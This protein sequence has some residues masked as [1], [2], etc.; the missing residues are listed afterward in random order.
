MGERA[1]H[2]PEV[3]PADDESGLHELLDVLNAPNTEDSLLDDQ[4]VQEILEGGEETTQSHEYVLKPSALHETKSL[5]ELADLATGSYKLETDA[6]DTPECYFHHTR[7]LKALQQDETG[8]ERVKSLSAV[9]RS[10]HP[11]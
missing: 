1:A 7:K 5:E 3:E 9:S 8:S 2:A 4:T 10:R 6:T 11:R